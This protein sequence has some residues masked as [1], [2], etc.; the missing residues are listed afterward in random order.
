[1]CYPGSHLPESSDC[2]FFLSYF[3]LV[4][5]CYIYLVEISCPSFLPSLLVYWCPAIFCYLPFRIRYKAMHLYT[6]TFM[7]LTQWLCDPMIQW[8][9][10][11]FTVMWSG[12][13]Q[14]LHS[15]SPPPPPPPLCREWQSLRMTPNFYLF[16]KPRSASSL[17]LS[18]EK[19]EFLSENK[20]CQILFLVFWPIIYPN[21]FITKNLPKQ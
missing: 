20:N 11:H 10:H 1:M 19:V 2:L 7:S 3:L 13:F 16:F 17:T 15:S 5:L 6:H 4:A 9:S 8:L 14:N 21:F 18:I 12:A